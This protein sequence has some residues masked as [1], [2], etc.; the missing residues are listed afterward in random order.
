MQTINWSK[1][2]RFQLT[3]NHA[4][5]LSMWWLPQ[6]SGYS[7]LRVAAIRI[8]VHPAG[9]NPTN[10]SRT[11]H[12][13]VH[14][15]PAYAFCAQSPYVATFH[16]LSTKLSRLTTPEKKGSR[17]N[18]QRAADRS[19]GPYPV[20]LPSQPMK[21]WGQSQASIN[22]RLLGLL[23]SYHQYAIGTFNTYSRGP[24]E[25]SLTDTGGGY[26]LGGANFSCTTPHPS[27]PA[28]SPFP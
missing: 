16:E 4:N 10:T 5:K 27:R 22:G 20:S 21:Q 15:C 14:I 7:Y 8:D 3:I 11:L 13:P 26:N 2:S 9:E 24:T 23:D 1:A 28:V 17:H 25:R 19:T 12:V 6:T 18:P